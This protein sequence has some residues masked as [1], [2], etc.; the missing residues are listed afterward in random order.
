MCYLQD[1]LAAYTQ[2]DV[3]AY[4][5]A[6]GRLFKWLTFALELRIE[7]VRMRRMKKK[8]ERDYREECEEREND[9]VEKRQQDME[10][11]REEFEA[12]L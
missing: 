10:K 2:E 6:L 12:A 7:D 8:K 4:S 1:N 9:R 5:T 11:A 3:D